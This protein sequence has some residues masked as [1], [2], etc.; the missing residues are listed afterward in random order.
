MKL[1]EPVTINGMILDNRI[2]L[3]AIVT[4]LSRE[5]GYVNQA[6]RDRYYRYAMGEVG[7]MVIEAMAVHSAKSGP[8]LRINDACFIPGLRDLVNLIHDTGP[9]KVAPQ[10]IHFLKISRSGWRQKP[11]DL[12]KE[13]IKDIVE[14]YRA[15]AGRAVEAGFDGVELHMAHA[16]TLSSFL[17]RLNNRNDEYGGQTLENRMR[18]MGEVI[19]NVRRE[20]GEGMPLGARFSAE[21][22]VKGGYTVEDSKQ[23]A[24]RMARLGIDWISL[25]AG[26]KFEDA[27]KK[28]GEPLYPYTGYSGDRCMPPDSYPDGANTYM[29]EAI[30]KC[31]NEQSFTTAVVTTGKIRTAEQAEGILQS[32]IADLVGMARALL[33]DPL[34]P[35]KIQQGAEETVIRCI[36]GNVCKSLDEN[37]KT[38]VCTLWPKGKIQ[39]PMSLDQV[40]P[41]WPEGGAQ[42]EVEEESTKVR[43]KWRPARDN[44]KV[45]GYEVFRRVNYGPWLHY[46]SVRGVTP[47]CVDTRVLCG[48]TYFYCVKAYDLAGNRSPASNHVNISAPLAIPGID[49]EEHLGKQSDAMG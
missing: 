46:T 47:Y 39:A 40:P 9:S 7:L 29:A 1:F 41:S 5:D 16:Y 43:L 27:R 10:I 36:Y 26:G 19:A 25:T 49:R 33:T 20:I 3:P 14:L 30:K 24:H 12:S 18:L 37:F 2:V 23:I 32:E 4:R 48:N 38:V 28:E 45:Y 17:S 44:E 22:C 35:K 42:L 31:I 15:A 21:E 6:V 13:E 34:L 11:E 8:L